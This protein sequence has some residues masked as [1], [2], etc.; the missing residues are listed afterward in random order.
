M[1][2]FPFQGYLLSLSEAIYEGRA[3]GLSSQ[4]SNQLPSRS[5]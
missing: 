1:N 3:R 5:K 2:T 4:K